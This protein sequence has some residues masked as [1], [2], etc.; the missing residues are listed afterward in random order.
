M[1]LEIETSDC[2]VTVLVEMRKKHV[3]EGDMNNKNVTRSSF[4]HN[5]LKQVIIRLDCEGVLQ[6]EMDE[7]LS[8][9]K[10]Y[11]KEKGFARYEQNANNEIIKVNHD[12]L[13]EPVNSAEET[14]SIV[15]HSFINDN[16]GY[17]VD[18]SNKHICVKVNT[19]KYI[20]FDEYAA[21]FM[22]I[23]NIYKTTID[24]FTMKRFGLRKI[25]FC[26]INNVKYVNK[27]FNQRYFDCYD[28]FDE[29]DIF[30]SEKKE[31]FLID[32]YKVNLLCDIEKG[33]LNDKTMYK[34]TLDTDIYIDDGSKIENDIFENKNISLLNEKIFAIYVDALSDEFG[35]ML[36]SDNDIDEKEIKGVESN[37]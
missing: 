12:G 4:K 25:N 21:T 35:Q 24:F 11:L 31:N 2:H 28:L 34:V 5:F 17:A 36:I 16:M 30:A 27:Y 14:Y 18:L 22:D 37:E 33:Q 6:S 1:K 9:V 32:G 13:F 8:K 23:S 10:P 3:V 19:P 20:P 26:F 29:S 7:V 15:I